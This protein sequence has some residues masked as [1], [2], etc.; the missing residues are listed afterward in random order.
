MPESLDLEMPN[1]LGALEPLIERVVALLERCGADASAVFAANLALE[2]LI[3]N[4]IKYGYDDAERHVI[5]VRAEIDFGRF[6]LRISDDGHPFN[7]FDQPT[8]DT[9]LPIEERP[10]GGLGIHFVRNLLDEYRH[11]WRDGRNVVTVGKALR[12]AEA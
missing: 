4:I 3:T 9:S 12:S 10:I 1:E 8:P 2:E 11:E 6:L 5:R 7:P